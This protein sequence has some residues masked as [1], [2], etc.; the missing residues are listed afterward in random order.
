MPVYIYPCLCWEDVA[1]ALYACRFSSFWSVRQCSCLP[2][3]K[4]KII[5]K[6]APHKIHTNTNN[7]NNSNHHNHHN[8]NMFQETPLPTKETSIYGIS[9]PKTPL[10]QSFVPSPYDILCGKGRD[11]LQNVG[12]QRLRVQIDMNLARYKVAHSRGQKSLIVSEI[13]EAARSYHPTRKGHFVRRQA[14]QWI[15]IGDD[16]AREKIGHTIRMSLHP[17]Q[18][19]IKKPSSCSNSSSSADTKNKMMQAKSKLRRKRLST[20]LSDTDSHECD[21]DE[22]QHS[23]GQQPQQ[24]QQAKEAEQWQEESSCVLSTHEPSKLSSSATMA[25]SYLASFHKDLLPLPVTAVVT[26][27]ASNLSG[28]ETVKGHLPL[29]PPCGMN[30]EVMEEEGVVDFDPMDA[31]H[32]FRV[33]ASL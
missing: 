4:Q 11:C 32:L 29:D 20:S 1:H 12:N 16:A 22:C 9:I 14:G 18:R 19:S 3:T 6:S 28:M 23:S 10:P 25:L 5:R 13:V 33:L 27:D 17:R 15:E 31:E 21:M 30:Y 8:I 7:K 24:Q 2:L 26:G